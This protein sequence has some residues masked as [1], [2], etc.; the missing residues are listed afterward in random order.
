MIV[1][2]GTLTP[3]DLVSSYFGGQQTF[4]CNVTGAAAVW[5]IRRF[6][7]DTSRLDAIK[8]TTGSTGLSVASNNTRITTT[9]TSGITPSSTITISGFIAEDTGLRIWCI[10]LEDNSV[11]GMVTI[12]IGTSMYYSR[13]VL[14]LACIIEYLWYVVLSC[15]CHLIC[16]L[17]VSFFLCRGDDTE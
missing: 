14:S 4:T 16:H 6:V 9:D 12:S 8:P 17:I 15:I 13:A 7:E 1:F 11:Q 3:H 10:N 2:V 5:N